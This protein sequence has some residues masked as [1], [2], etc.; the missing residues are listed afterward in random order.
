MHAGNPVHPSR[1]AAAPA[2]CRRYLEERL[3][4]VFAAAASLGLQDAEQARVANVTHNLIGHPTVGASWEGFVI[5]NLIAAAGPTR[6]PYFFRTADGTEVDLVF[7][8]AGRVELAIEVKR[9]TAPVASRAFRSACDAIKP[10]A[11]CIVH[12]GDDTWPMGGGVTAIALPELMKRLL[13]K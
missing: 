11:A 12:G 1:R 9:S 8:R 10:Q 5:E 6:T 2:E 7:E 4:A 13:R 3:H